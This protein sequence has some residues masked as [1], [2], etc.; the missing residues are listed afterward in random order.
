MI[1]SQA[2]K[3]IHVRLGQTPTVVSPGVWQGQHGH[4]TVT[5]IEAYPTAARKSEGVMMRFQKL[6]S[7]AAVRTINT[8][9]TFG[10]EVNDLTDATMCAIIAW[11]FACAPHELE[12]PID[13]VGD[14]GWIFVPRLSPV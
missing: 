12:H 5:I 9:Q 11:M 4:Q 7:E 14:E 1:G 3:G 13:G 6:V 10:L 2:T 8:S